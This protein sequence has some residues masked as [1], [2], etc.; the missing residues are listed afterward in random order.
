MY[1]IFNQSREY[2]GN[3]TTL[4]RLSKLLN[5]PLTNKIQDNL[6]GIH[7]YKFG[8]LVINYDINYILIIGGTDVNVDINNDDKRE[9]IMK[10]F[11]KAKFIV[12]FNNFIKNILPNHSAKIKVIPQSVSQ[13][14]P[15]NFNIK[16]HLKTK[17]NISKIN[18]LFVIVGNL[19]PI[20][21][22]LYLKNVFKEL[23]KNNIYCILIG[24][25][26]KSEYKFGKGMIH[27]GP[28]NQNDITACYQQV[29]GLINCSVSEGMS[30]SILEAMINKCPVYVRKNPGN[31]AIVKHLENGY[32]FKDPKEFLKII[33]L[34][35]KEI[36]NNAYRYVIK[37]HNPEDEKNE[38]LKMIQ[39]LTILN[40]VN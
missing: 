38:Y 6:I 25:I 26:I 14:K 9:T 17:F 27:I 34:N 37:N 5:L 18:K 20:K 1:S 23:S 31:C 24:R 16:N 15:S 2:S 7:A 19:R 8:K 36:I 29:N 33:E 28:L 40:P 39:D 32:V 11:Q 13:I 3:N 10:A 4:T 35:N 21:D 30:V 22:P 12:S